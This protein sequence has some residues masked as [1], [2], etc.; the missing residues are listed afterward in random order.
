MRAAAMRL[1]LKSGPLLLGTA[2]Q[3]QSQ[4]SSWKP[5]ESYKRLAGVRSLRIAGRRVIFD[6]GDASSEL[7]SSNKLFYRQEDRSP[8]KW[9]S[10]FCARFTEWPH[11]LAVHELHARGSQ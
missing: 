6:E 2:S 10:V 9:P 8:R 3:D 7:R 1:L 4:S 5:I 11:V